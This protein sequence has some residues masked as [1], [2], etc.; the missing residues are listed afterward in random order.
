M[1]RNNEKNACYIEL[2]LNS[3]FA[4]SI[5]LLLW[6]K[7]NIFNIKPFLFGAE[8]AISDMGQ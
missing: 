7:V 4:F 3:K 1:S 6:R 2:T 8:G 5:S